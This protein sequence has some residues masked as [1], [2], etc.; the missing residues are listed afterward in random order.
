MMPTRRSSL[1]VVAC[2]LFVAAGLASAQRGPAAN[3]V[4]KANA[5]TKIADHT[6]M[7]ADDN[8]SFVPN[9]GIVV[10]A[11][12]T[13]VIDP[14]LGRANGEVVR[15]EMEKISRNQRVYLATT[16]FHPEH[17][18]G[19][20]AFPPEAQYINSTTQEAEWADSGMQMVQS[21]SKIS[22]AM[23][24]MLADAHRR[25][26]DVTFDREYT[27]DLGGVTV[28]MLMVGPTH[29]RGDTAFFVEQDRVLFAGDV[30]MNHSFLAAGA[31][32]SMKA[33]MSAFDAFEAWKP[34]IVVPAHGATG[35]GDLIGV[36]RGF[37]TEIQTRARALK[38]EGRSIDEVAKTVTAELTA[39]HP[40]WPRAS[41]IANAARSAYTEAP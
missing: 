19:Y 37:M 41:G 18:T 23:Q 13:L 4:V 26:A 14:G 7:I 35:T 38:A 5:T 10:G 22:P 36:N 40:D 15:R 28:R 34:T 12:A 16:H 1:V 32:A 20:L 27:L 3:P 24:E 39:K 11:N 9:V 29:T 30:V 21:F 31:N 8:V 33:W 6:W 17:T 25:V 2:G